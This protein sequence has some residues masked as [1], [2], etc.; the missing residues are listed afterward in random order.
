MKPAIIACCLSLLVLV[1]ASC[2]KTDNAP[3][4]SAPV[5]STETPATQATPRKE[6]VRAEAQA[7][8]ATAGN[9]AEATVRVLIAENYHI[10]AN[11]PSLPH[12]IPTELK[13][14]AEGGISAAGAPVYPSS[15]TKKFAFAEQPIKVYEGVAIIKLPLRIDASAT[16]GAHQL[17]G[18]LRA[19]PCDNQACY[20]PRTVETM[21]PVNVR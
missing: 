21:I 18:K 3:T 17:H 9:P 14:E 16:K 2:A 7:I 12:L 11:P 1:A 15:V 13:I 8:E 20:P 19:Q 5:A 10:N 6:I 4:Q